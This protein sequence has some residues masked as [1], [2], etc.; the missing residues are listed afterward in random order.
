[1][2]NKGPYIV[3]AIRTLDDILKRMSGHQHKKMARLR[4][5]RLASLTKPPPQ[6][7]PPQQ[8]PPGPPAQPAAQA[9]PP[10]PATQ[11]PPPVPPP[12]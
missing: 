3:E 12:A 2:L 11:P 8:T 1:M 4:P 5:L 6:P 7:A 9:A 10:A